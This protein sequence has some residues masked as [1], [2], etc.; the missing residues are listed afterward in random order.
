[1]HVTRRKE[2]YTALNYELFKRKGF[3]VKFRVKTY[4]D[5]QNNQYEYYH[6]EYVFNTGLKRSA[7]ISLSAKGYIQA[8]ISMPDG[9]KQLFFMGEA[10]KNK[11][12]RKVSKIVAL[13]EAYEDHEIDIV[14]VDSSGT[15]ISSKFPKSEKAIMGRSTISV[16]VC[17][18]EEKCDIGI[19]LQ[20]DDI[21]P[22]ILSMNDFLE[23]YYTLK[24]L[25]Y[26]ATTISVL[27]YLGP[28][29]LG[30]HE[31]DFRRPGVLDV[32]YGEINTESTPMNNSMSDFNEIK[33]SQTLV[34]NKKINW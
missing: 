17:I 3:I 24:D 2:D 1:M 26:S 19:A 11:F 9:S 8:D 33:D 28:P 22:V 15:H 4:N 7:T 32:G 31:T 6:K 5:L 20:F 13:L 27:N 34:S 10:M 18:R 21:N 14:T 29:E 12:I 30:S 23:L 25:S 16:L